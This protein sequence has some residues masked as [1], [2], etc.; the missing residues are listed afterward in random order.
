[1]NA[2]KTLAVISHSVAILVSIGYF[3]IQ[4]KLNDTPGNKK[5]MPRNRLHCV[6]L[7][8]YAGMDITF[9]VDVVYST[10]DRERHDTVS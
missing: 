3:A 8:V 5:K 6:L 9:S 7:C 1:M 2:Y 10:N 4:N